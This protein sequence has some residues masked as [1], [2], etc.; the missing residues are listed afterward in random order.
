QMS[1]RKLHVEAEGGA[2]RCVRLSDK[3]M[4]RW[5]CG[6][7]KTPLGNTMTAKMPFVGVIHSFMDHAASG[8]SREEALGPA[9]PVQTETAY[10]SGAPK[11]KVSA[12]ITV[13]LRTM[14]KVLGWQITGAGRPSP[15]FDAET[16]APRAAP[17]VLDAEARRA[18][19]RP[20][21][22]SAAAPSS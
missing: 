8:V 15:F 13:L 20:P 9:Q 16:G 14:T 21:T 5:Y 4:H 11:Q 22:S 17:E 3:G 12:L 6:E 1:P 7:C 18:L 2:L 19:D 10:G